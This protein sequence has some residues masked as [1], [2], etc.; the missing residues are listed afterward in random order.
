MYDESDYE[1]ELVYPR[2]AEEFAGFNEEQV[3][4]QQIGLADLTKTESIPNG[5]KAK[6]GPIS[7]P[8][9]GW[10]RIQPSG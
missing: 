7:P 3:R 1:L 5:F 9:A 2:P 10:R 6:L 4:G 8:G